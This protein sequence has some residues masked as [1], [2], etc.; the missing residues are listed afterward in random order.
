MNKY[1]SIF[2]LI[3]TTFSAQTNYNKLSLEISS[4]YTSPVQPY[5]S[6]YGSNFSSFNLINIGGRYM[7]SEKFGVRLEYV[8]DRFVSNNDASVGTYF[9]RFGAQLVYNLGK[10]LDL[11]YLTNEQFGILTHAGVGYTRSTIKNLRV[12][13]QIGSVVIGITPQYK[14]NDRTA[15]FFDFSSIYNFKQHYRYDGTLISP[16]FV[17]T[18]GNH[19]NISLGIILY[20]GQN[21]LHSDWY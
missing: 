9:N 17:P 8:N 12:T 14:V 18:V 19:Y 6:N 21:R 3:S 2:L 5:L 1:I 7:F 10:D 13:E 4:G 11:L 20:I 16:D 15:L